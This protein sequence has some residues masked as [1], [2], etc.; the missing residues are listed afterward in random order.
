MRAT[1]HCPINEYKNKTVA[2]EQLAQKIDKLWRNRWKMSAAFAIITFCASSCC[3]W[4]VTRRR[5]PFD[6]SRGSVHRKKEPRTWHFPDFVLN[7]AR[8]NFPFGIFQCQTGFLLPQGAVTCGS[9]YVCVSFCRSRKGAASTDLCSNKNNK[10]AP[11]P[12]IQH[13]VYK[14]LCTKV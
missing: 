2:A 4:K 1:F 5:M 13:S 9:F 12:P 14:N 6:K 8:M 10:R 3:K 7:Y 11:R